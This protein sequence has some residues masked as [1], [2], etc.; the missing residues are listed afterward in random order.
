MPQLLWYDEAEDL[1]DTS[2]GDKERAKCAGRTK[3]LLLL[4]KIG[5]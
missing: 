5:L 4:F 2:T 1:A 3:L